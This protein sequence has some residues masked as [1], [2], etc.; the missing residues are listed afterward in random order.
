MVGRASP[1]MRAW[2][3]ERA[4]VREKRGRGDQ[5]RI[6]RP[7]GS[8]RT[9]AWQSGG[10]AGHMG[11]PLIPCSGEGCQRTKREVRKEKPGACDPRWLSSDMGAS[12]KVGGGKA[13]REPLWEVGIAMGSCGI[14]VPAS[15]SALFIRP[16][17]VLDGFRAAIKVLTDCLLIDR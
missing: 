7:H 9:A 10:W 11:C 1:A 2:L 16:V 8:G 3:I 17:A 4:V 13:C 15:W 5:R 14:P 12:F 6:N